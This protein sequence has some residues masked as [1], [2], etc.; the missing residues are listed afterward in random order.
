MSTYEEVILK[1][2][3]SLNEYLQKSYEHYDKSLLTLSF[4]SIVI[5]IT[6]VKNL[7]PD[8]K[9]VIH[10]SLMIAWV[11]WLLS[12]ISVL[13]SFMASQRATSKMIQE[14]D[15]G[16]RRKLG[17]SW[18]VVTEWVNYASGVFYLTGI[19]S[20]IYFAYFHLK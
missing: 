3:E 10:D 5:S 16:K 8:G 18:K 13:F 7:F 14:L 4:G 20:M 12:A 1:Y 11:F 9:I 6:F 15:T 17:G 19:I 2:R